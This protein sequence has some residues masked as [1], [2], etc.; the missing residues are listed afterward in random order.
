MRT[1]LC[2]EIAVSSSFID[3]LETDYIGMVKSF[4]NLNL[5][6]KHLQAGG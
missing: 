1:V 6:V 5:I 4:Q 3:I 2:N